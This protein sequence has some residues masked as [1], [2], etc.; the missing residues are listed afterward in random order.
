MAEEKLGYGNRCGWPVMPFPLTPAL[1]PGERENHRQRVG[2]AGTPG[3]FEKWSA[4]LPLPKGEGWG[5]GERDSLLSTSPGATR[6]SPRSV[7]LILL[8]AVL[9]CTQS[10]G[11]PPAL[12]PVVEAEDNVYTYTNADNGAGPLWCHGSTCLVRIGKE[13]FASGLDTLPNLKPLNNC[14]WTL[15]QR[16]KS[17]WQLQVVDETGRTREP[18]PMVGFPDGRLFLSANPTLT[19]EGIYAGPAR[20]EILQFAA[21]DVKAPFERLLPVWDGKPA[22]T[23]HSYRSFAADGPGHELILFQNIGYTHAEWAFRDRKGKWVSQGKL[24]WPDGTDYPKPEPIRVCYPNV[25]LKKRA[26][27]FC[28]VSDIIEPYP[29]WRAYKKQLTGKEWDYD[30]RRLFYT[31]TPDITREKFRPWVEIASRDKTCGWVSPGDLWVGPDDTVHLVWTERALD[32]RLRA[33]FFPEVKQS[34]AVNYAAVRE[35]KVVL[36]RT[37]MRS[38]EG[39]PGENGASPRFQ[40]TPDNRLFVICYV[41]G[42]GADGKAVSE[43]RLIEIHP[44]GE[45]GQSIKVPFTKPFTAYFTATVRGGSPASKTLDLL[46]ERQGAPGTMS[47]GRVALW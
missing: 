46:G 29:E 24:P 33:K 12:R 17:G 14:R 23:E 40:V 27:H 1:S 19:S 34:H 39:K 26:V 28:G 13:V 47:Y 10:I 37:L 31:W 32:E 41:S 15:Y 11:A 18:A 6:S 45:L 44:G 30:F 9:T 35:G 8:M 25:Q 38:E 42:Q 20:P 43:N 3:M 5:E 4:R 7:A 2:E 21:R 22:F 16:G 36:R